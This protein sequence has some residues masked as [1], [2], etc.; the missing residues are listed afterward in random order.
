MAIV[1][2]VVWHWRHTNPLVPKE[3]LK[4]S[5]AMGSFAINLLFFYAVS[6]L[7]FLLPTVLQRDSAGLTVVGV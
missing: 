3:V 7:R 1:A 6:V 4:N 2:L 5:V